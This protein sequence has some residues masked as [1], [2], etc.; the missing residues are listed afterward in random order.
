MDSVLQVTSTE[1]DIINNMYNY[2]ENLCDMYLSKYTLSKQK[3]AV[4]LETDKFTFWFQPNLLDDTFDYFFVDY[5]AELNESESSLEFENIER[6]KH[7]VHNHIN[8]KIYH[9]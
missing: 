5:F 2:L 9:C 3:S 7:L 1:L 6:I 8:P 4:T